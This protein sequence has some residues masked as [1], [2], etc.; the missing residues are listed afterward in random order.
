M[1]LMRVSQSCEGYFEDA[2]TFV[3]YTNF[4]EELCP[5]SEVEFTLIIAS[6]SKHCKING[7]LGN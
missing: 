3:I 4:G 2:F 6:R 7:Q 1:I 5:R